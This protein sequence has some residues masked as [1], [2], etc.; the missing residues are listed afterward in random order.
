M[1]MIEAMASGTPVVAMRRGSV[2]EVVRHGSTGWI[3]DQESELAAALGRVG[4]LAADDCVAHARSAFGA[5][6]M[7]SRYEQ[8]YRHAIAQ[9]LR[10]RRSP[11]R[12]PAMAPVR[13]LSLAANRGPV[14]R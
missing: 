6:L 4:E 12:E 8:V 5:D 2:P 13:R 3:C 11:R 9:T 10:I 14:A 1:V 7:A